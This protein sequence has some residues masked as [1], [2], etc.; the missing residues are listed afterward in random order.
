[1][2]TL[3]HGVAAAVTGVFALFG[4][5]FGAPRT[6]TIAPQS[7]AV[8]YG[9]VAPSM[10]D[11]ETPVQ[12]T[13][14]SQTATATATPPAIQS[15]TVAIATTTPALLPKITLTPTSST[16]AKTQ[17]PKA[18]P[19][20]KPSPSPAPAPAPVATAPVVSLSAE[21]IL[22]RTSVAFRSTHDGQYEVVLTTNTGGAPLIWNLTN[23]TIGGSDAAPA[24]SVAYTCDP[25]PQSPLP[26]AIDQNPTFAVRSS[27]NCTISLTPIGG[28]DRR[29]Q[30]HHFPFTTPSGE[31][32][33]SPPSSMST[34][35]SNDTNN[36][37]FVF[38]NQD[39]APVTITGLTFDVSFQYL[40]TVYGPLVLRMVDPIT[41]TSLGDY[42]L[43]TTP[44]DPTKEFS[45]HAPNVTIPISFTVKGSSQKLLPIEILGVHKMLIDKTTPQVT[46]TLT[47]I[48]TN[49]SDTKTTLNSATISWSCDVVIGGYDPNAT[50]GPMAT[51]RICKN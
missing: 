13:V 41:E 29:T 2:Q 42:H 47:G 4:G 30:S 23:T 14:N 38:N 24:F 8:V 11:P 22:N 7:A 12:D 25:P 3:F 33:V 40:T 5:L 6:I 1:M 44:V 21:D 48:T 20:P 36:G 17:E 16:V 19:T 50:S 37:G 32:I 46:L 45:Y 10:I 39:G 34:I 51:G 28:T 9:V 27:Y 43:E 31:L 49:P 35:L 18:T 26:G 15:F